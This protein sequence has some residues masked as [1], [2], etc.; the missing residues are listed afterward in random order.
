MSCWKAITVISLSLQA[1]YAG[2]VPKP[3]PGGGTVNRLVANGDELCAGTNRGIYC[4]PADKEEW[5]QSYLPDQS[6][7]GL[8][9]TR[10]GWVA[11]AQAADSLDAVPRA[12]LVSVDAGAHWS[13]REIGDGGAGMLQAS[14]DSVSYSADGIHLSIDG[15]LTW[16]SLAVPY[17]GSI[18]GSTVSSGAVL[19]GISDAG[20]FAMRNGD[21]AWSLIGEGL[22]LEGFSGG[23]AYAR[24]HDVLGGAR[25]FRVGPAGM[26]STEP[27]QG[28]LIFGTDSL[29]MV[30]DASDL[31]F[32]GRLPYWS[33][34]KDPWGDAFSPGVGDQWIQGAGFLRARS[35]EIYRVEARNT[36]LLIQPFGMGLQ[37]APVRLEWNAGIL[38]A[39]TPGGIYR[40]E[41]G[42]A[43][44][45]IYRQPW[46]I[47][48][49]FLEPGTGYAVASQPWFDSLRF[50]FDEGL[51]W[52]GSLGGP[53]GWV[54]SMVKAGATYAVLSEAVATSMHTLFTSTDLG[55]PWTSRPVKG[56]PC[57]DYL[58]SSGSALL[59]ACD[60][61]LWRST[62]Y[63]A[64]WDPILPSSYNG[65]LL[66]VEGGRVLYWNMGQGT[67]SEE[68]LFESEDSGASWN[69][70]PIPWPKD[71]WLIDLAIS[72]TD[73]FALV[74]ELQGRALTRV[75]PLAGTGA[76]W[77]DLPAQA[78]P[79]HGYSL[80]AHEGKLWVGLEENG[81]YELDGPTLPISPR[82]SRRSGI[83]K[84]MVTRLLPDRDALGRSAPPSRSRRE[85]VLFPERPK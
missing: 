19:C 79:E 66:T 74:W 5:R 73:A 45:P 84:G 69:P 48:C 34:A 81:I 29:M 20:I 64:H 50:S 27:V 4:T 41:S 12:F 61:A 21:T 59:I 6:V 76:A 49:S 53:T 82:G 47:G 37:Q 32:T 17:E 30:A 68:T 57:S 35:G 54:H 70:L 62:D 55:G 72:G 15:G 3:G 44:K 43:W 18:V 71:S 8:A 2:W 14:G 16:K 13:K 83:E 77:R 40:Q 85:L 58:K 42:G 28:H 23:K 22:A 39:Q 78:I 25:Y 67:Q 46:N 60:S 33:K 10:S 31:L 38:F 65:H 75:Y 52:S 11:V 9:K 63:G 24:G 1:A 7:W 51:S 56:P 26:D 80:S 36:L